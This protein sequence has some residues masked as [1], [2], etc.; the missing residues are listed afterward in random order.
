MMNYQCVKLFLRNKLK[1][2]GKKCLKNEKEYL[3][4]H[5]ALRDLHKRVLITR[6]SPREFFG[7]S[8]EALKGCLQ[9]IKF[10]LKKRLNFFQKRP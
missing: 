10:V 9:M 7:F 2:V 3:S 5:P 6:S 1:K 4:L 8:F